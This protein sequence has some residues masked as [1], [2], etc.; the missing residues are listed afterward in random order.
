MRLH[1]TVQAALAACAT[2]VTSAGLVAGA[3]T[4]GAAPTS[5][6]TVAAGSSVTAAAP[7]PTR[8]FAPYLESWT[9]ESP[10]ALSAQSGAKHLTMAFLQTA[11][12]GSCT[13]YWNG[14]TALPIAQSSFGADFATIR[15]NGG[16]VIPSFGGYTADTTGT[17]LADSCTDV[18]QIAAAYQKLITTYDISR[19]D[20]DI[21]ADSL[22]NSAG[23]DRR[24][25]AIKLTQD[26]AA[27]NGRQIQFAYTLPTT[28][29]GPAANGIALLKNAVANNAR[30]DV[31]NLMTFDYYDNATHD[32]AVDTQTAVTGLYNQ[33]AK[34]YP[35]R[36]PS[37]LW[38]SIGI[39]EMPGI[40]DFGAAETFTLA[41][42]TSVY[43]WALSKGIN[44]LSF[45]ALQRDTGKCPGVGGRDDCSGIQ[46]N[47]WDFS[48]IF[49]PFT[50]NYPPNSDFSITVNPG[51]GTVAAGSSTTATVATAEITTPGSPSGTAPSLTLSVSGA[52]AGVTATVN[53]GS[54]LAG[55]PATLTVNTAATTVP[56]TYPLTVTGK[57]TATGSVHTATYT[58]TV[59]GTQPGND[60]SVGVNPAA[61]SVAAGSSAS[62]TVN[63][64][65]VSG[66]A[67]SVALSVSG[68]PAGVTATVNPGSV[69]AGTPA[70]LTVNTAATTVPGTYPLTVTGTAASGSHTATYTLTVTGV[71]PP[72]GLA[73]GG[74]ETGSLGPWTCQAGGSVVST[75]VHSG[76]YALQAAA[77]ASQTGECAQTVTLAP[78]KAY[79]LTGWVQGNYSYIGVSGGATGSAWTSGSGWTK[80]SVPFTTG[81]SG[82]VTVYLHGWYGQG[83]VYGD[84]FSIA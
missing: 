10:A 17:E 44:T 63:T 66:S 82:T 31:V 38:N 49:A 45:W 67:Q 3:T 84:D 40:D 77:T 55:T 78:N 65:V 36:T 35:T 21:E 60:F 48:K 20:L 71:T 61:G 8:V 54:V 6:A 50:S 15:A 11:T 16:D 43:N 68:A 27:A 42:A 2:L 24:N 56:G 57:A 76:S 81:A 26:W 75:P 46:Q 39:I 29:S 72:G 62:A 64:G 34:L 58:L 7:L 33:L 30:I 47:N 12:K 19:I 14:N 52:P 70:T 59:S 53:P 18:N 74:L 69:L 13:P 32:M 79:T 4:A 80:L 51:S 9:G 1:R 28:T 22:D 83:N 41:N 73:N 25:K 23:V 5:P 37:Q